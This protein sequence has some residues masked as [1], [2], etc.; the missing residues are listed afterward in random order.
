MKHNYE[1]V[2]QWVEEIFNY[3][4]EYTTNSCLIPY[5]DIDSFDPT[6]KT[7]QSDVREYVVE[8]DGWFNEIQSM[9][10]NDLA[11]VIVVIF[12]EAP[13]KKEEN[14]TMYCVDLR[15]KQT[16]HS[17]LTI[18][19]TDD[20]D[21][22]WGVANNYNDIHG[23]TDDEI[24]MLNNENTYGCTQHPYWATVYENYD[25]VIEPKFE[26]VKEMKKYTL[27]NYKKFTDE[28]LVCPPMEE[29]EDGTIDEDKWY[30]DHKIRIIVGEHEIAIDY[31]ADSVNEIDFALREMYEEEYGN[32]NPTTGNTVGSEY[33]PAE[34][35]DIIRVALQKAWDEY[36]W[37]VGNLSEFLAQFIGTEFLM[38]DAM[39]WYQIIL[40]DIK[41]YTDC[42]HCN[43]GKLNMYSMRNI[44]ARVVRDI[45]KEL[46]GTDRELLVGY[47]NEHK[48]SDITFVM[49]YTIKQSGDLIGWFYGDQDPKYINELVEDY[50]KKLL[51]EEE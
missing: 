46:I 7:V 4:M 3:T 42:Y 29:F 45:V 21:D 37:K 38:S 40:E 51:G 36:G 35:K 49:D 19:K 15:S 23:N 17:V 6:D 16:H 9:D 24:E 33:R 22:A 25:E 44:N 50:K 43:F 1:L 11:Q 5:G 47:D 30:E 31:Y 13:M 18:F 32:G 39:N 2:K 48:C 28:A 14:K 34:L 41:H 27:E 26:E 8:S 12:Y 10:F 20:Y